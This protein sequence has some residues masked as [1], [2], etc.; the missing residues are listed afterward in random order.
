M[1]PGSRIRLMFAAAGAALLAACS[2]DSGGTATVPRGAATVPA[3]PSA[4][5]AAPREPDLSS[6]QTVATG[7]EVPW[8]L[9]FLPD[10]SALV[11][12]RNRARILR[13]PTGGGDPQEV[14]RV[15]GVDATGEGGLLGLAVD[16]GYARN[17]YVY[18]YFTAADDN[19]IIRFTLNGRTPEV[20]FDGI[21][22]AGF[23]NGG[24][25]A[26]GPDGMLYVGTGDAGDQA[27][28]QNP[29]DVNGKILRIT[30]DG[31]PAPGNPTAGSPVWS[32][33]H[34][35]VQGLAWDSKGTMYGIEFG[36]RTWDEVNEIAR[37]APRWPGS[38]RCSPATTAGCARWGW[39]R[40]ARSGSPRRTGTAGATRATGTTGSCASRRRSRPGRGPGGR[41]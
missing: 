40:T 23:H 15:A 24:R 14:Y 38:R 9:A 13:I 32:L 29:K 6:P 20:I 19:R 28:S 4:S 2:T 16:P 3:A 27:S 33:G 1:T 41:R 25:I 30:R 10:G 11:A 8:G 26:F 21:D 18:A 37:A 39:R 17:G 5:G 34:R 35:N 12:E 36:Q 22:K 31:K 7:L